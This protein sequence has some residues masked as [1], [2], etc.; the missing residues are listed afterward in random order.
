MGCVYIF[1]LIDIDEDDYLSLMDD[2]GETRADL[3]V[4]GG[5]LGE[6]LRAR[7]ENDEETVCTVLAAMGHEA[8]I[9]FKNS[10]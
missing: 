7:F 10:K 1:Q 2:N 3:K 8:V 5:E 6:K 9:E 4:P